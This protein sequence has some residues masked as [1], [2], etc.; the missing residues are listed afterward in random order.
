MF[1]SANIQKYVNNKLELAIRI[2]I[3]NSKNLFSFD[4]FV[5]M[6]KIK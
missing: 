3:L 2:E 1:D 6:L 5:K 4:I